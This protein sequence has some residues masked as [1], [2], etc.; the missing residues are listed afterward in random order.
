[1]AGLRY[2]RWGWGTAGRDQITLSIR[3]HIKECVLSYRKR[4]ANELKM[5]TLVTVQRRA[6]LEEASRPV[7]SQELVDGRRWDVCE[8]IRI[9]TSF[10]CGR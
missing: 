5:S 8:K 1:M 3:A 10:G 6:R 4:E 9:M 2:E 7:K